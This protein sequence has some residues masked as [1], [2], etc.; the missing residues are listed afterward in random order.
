[1]SGP[2]GLL[3][4]T[5]GINIVI[6][7][8]LAGNP[9]ITSTGYHLLAAL[10]N[11]PQLRAK[12]A[13]AFV[14]KLR[15]NVY[16]KADSNIL[17]AYA[18]ASLLF[19]I[20]TAAVFLL[21]LNVYLRFQL[22]GFGVFLT[23]LFILLLIWRFGGKVK[24]I[25]EFYE[26]S[27]QFDH[28][29]T[30]ALPKVD[31]IVAKTKSKKSPL[32]HVSV[33][34][35]LAVVVGLLL[36]YH[37]EPGGD[38]IILPNQKAELTSQ[39]A[40]VIDKVYFDGG[41]FLKKGTVIAELSTI[42]YQGQM[43]IY[44]AKVQ[45]QQAVINDLKSR[46]KPEE[47]KLAERQLEVQEARTEFSGEKF[48][49][50][51]ELYEEKTISLDEF[52]RQRRDHEVDLKQEEEARANLALVKAGP[53]PDHIAAEEGK[54]QSY[55][56]ER[57]YYKEKIAQSFIYMPFDG[58]LVGINLKQKAGHYLNQG[59][60]FATAENTDQV[61]AQVEVPESDI[62]YVIGQGGTKV[63]SFTYST[64]DDFKG[65]VT[66][67]DTIVTEKRP[68]K[69]VR[70]LTLLDNKDGR[71][72]S[73]MTGYAKISSKTMPTWKVLSLAIIRFFEVEVWSWI[74]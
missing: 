68:G 45:E 31:D 62:G 74:P 40:G 46:P 71:L 57:D 13:F 17:V 14:N 35:A 16:Q 63:R 3:A 20:G 52:E 1:M 4:A 10:L 66:E 41:E 15:G 59:E 26:R 43:K 54:L 34:V 48:S 39:N 7:F 50:Y 60:V 49:R 24:L 44:E 56:E 22:G 53:T 12:T 23:V 64:D 67:I 18:L 51:K 8:F 61:F 55:K 38:F 2:L 72:K 5:I 36:P 28:W 33:Y 11:E 58:T 73:G 6:S 30:R 69:V 27:V 21:V 70:V 37:Y 29:K 32:S 25:T 42:D 9:L 65:V 19:M 47:I